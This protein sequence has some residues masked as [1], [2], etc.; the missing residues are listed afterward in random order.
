MDIRAQNT[1]RPELGLE[2]YVLFSLLALTHFNKNHADYMINPPF[3]SQDKYK[4]CQD[5]THK[6]PH[7]SAGTWA[8]TAEKN[9]YICAAGMQGMPVSG[10]PTTLEDRGQDRS[11][12]K[13]ENQL[14]YWGRSLVGLLMHELHHAAGRDSKYIKMFRKYLRAANGIFASD[15]DVE[16]PE[17]FVPPGFPAVGVVTKTYRAYGYA[18]IS[19]LANWVQTD[20]SQPPNTLTHNPDTITYLAMAI[21]MFGND[22]QDNKAKPVVGGIDSNPADQQASAR[23]LIRDAIA[24][25]HFDHSGIMGT[26]FLS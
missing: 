20:T 25:P 21:W 8:F 7:Y 17:K 22:W 3:E 26:R 15:V 16:I 12:I 4:I 14:E 23:K 18:G 2:E 6:G 5:P 9:V 10:F 19:A 24:V 13:D 11:N 1:S